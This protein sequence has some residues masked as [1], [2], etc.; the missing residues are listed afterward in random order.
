MWGKGAARGVFVG[1]LKK[2]PEITTS[3]RFACGCFV[4]T[5]RSSD[6]DA[7]R[8]DYVVNRQHGRL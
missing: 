8:G 7:W 3:Y 4:W 1:K 6:S 2:A 5:K